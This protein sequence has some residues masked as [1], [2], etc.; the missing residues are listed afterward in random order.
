MLLSVSAAPLA[1]VK[2][3]LAVNV[4]VTVWPAPR[5]VP[6]EVTSVSDVT[7]GP[8]VVILTPIYGVDHKDRYEELQNV[9]RSCSGER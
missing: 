6:F 7:V 8:V 2:A 5:S 9:T 3:S 4:N 1:I